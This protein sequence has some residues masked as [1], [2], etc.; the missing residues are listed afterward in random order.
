MRMHLAA[1]ILLPFMSIG[2][3][4]NESNVDIERD[5]SDRAETQLDLINGDASRA[6]LFPSVVAVETGQ[7]SLNC[8]A[9][10]VGPR[11]FLSAAH[12][13]ISD[14]GVANLVIGTSA[15]KS[16]QFYVAKHATENY[17]LFSPS[18]NVGDFLTKAKDFRMMTV[19][20]ERLDDASRRMSDVATHVTG[21]SSVSDFPVRRNQ[22]LN[23]VGAGC[24]DGTRTGLRVSIV[25]GRLIL[26]AGSIQVGIVN[27]LAFAATIGGVGIPARAGGIYLDFS[28][29]VSGC[30]GDS[31]GPAF[32]SAGQITGVFA[33]SSPVGTFFS[34]ISGAEK[35]WIGRKIATPVID[36]YTDVEKSNY[37]DDKRS[38][39]TKAPRGKETL[40]IGYKLLGSTLTFPG[41]KTLTV[42]QLVRK[43]ASET[44]V[45][46]VRIPADAPLG[47][48][49]IK[50]S[51]TAAPHGLLTSNELP[52][53]ITGGTEIADLSAAASDSAALADLINDANNVDPTPVEPGKPLY[54]E[55]SGLGGASFVVPGVTARLTASAVNLPV[56]HPLY[57]AG[58]EVWKLSIPAGAVVGSSGVIRAIISIDGVEQSFESPRPVTIKALGNGMKYSSFYRVSIGFPANFANVR[59]CQTLYD[60]IPTTQD[61]NLAAK[62]YH[63]IAVE[64]LV[65]ESGPDA[66]KIYEKEVPEQCTFFGALSISVSNIRNPSFSESGSSQAT[67][68]FL[69]GYDENGG[70][71]TYTTSFGSNGFLNYDFR[72]DGFCD[73]TR[74]SAIYQDVDGV[75]V[76]G[77]S[78]T[79]RSDLKYISSC[80]DETISR[81]KGMSFLRTVN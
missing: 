28:G 6:L 74:Y 77:R 53:N 49:K 72:D 29:S 43:N 8:T 55:G 51:Y 79:V 47:L 26:R 59:G 78:G 62:I 69:E 19:D 81:L 21:R 61:P 16:R 68:R 52:I 48:G 73:V 58:A 31:G 33:A 10:R 76:N 22:V 20:E 67:I 2:C 18:R 13:K 50:V 65:V 4:K 75:V 57:V 41:G 24:T 3:G 12:C 5:I 44:E 46:K 45:V 9:T 38:P 56:D 34:K 66:G 64:R 80:N 1:Y 27:S 11:H 14:E 32:D 40:L 39:R 25:D 15:S 71:K 30:E 70:V 7:V 37:I 63:Y 54:L 17:P 42:T 35:I 60:Q 23:V 36:R